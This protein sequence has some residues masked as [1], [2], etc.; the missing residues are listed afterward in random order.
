MPLCR[1]LSG[2]FPA[3]TTVGDRPTAL[4]SL[5]HCL[6]ASE[7]GAGASGHMTFVASLPVGV[8]TTA[9]ERG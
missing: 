1:G 7:P 3:R 4:R 9:K 5:P 6:W 2:P 8:M